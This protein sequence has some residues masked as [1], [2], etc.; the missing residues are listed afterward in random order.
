[1]VLFRG[2]IEIFLL[3]AII[4]HDI[5]PILYFSSRHPVI[6]I[7]PILGLGTVR[8]SPVAGNA[9]YRVEFYPMI[10][11]KTGLKKEQNK[12]PLANKQRKETSVRPYIQKLQKPQTISAQM[13]NHYPCESDLLCQGPLAGVSQQGAPQTPR[14]QYLSRHWSAG[15][16]PIVAKGQ[17]QTGPEAGRE[18]R[19]LPLLQQ[20][21]EEDPL[22][23]FLHAVGSYSSLSP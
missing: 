11:Q 20:H 8:A 7:E 3:P 22:D 23:R 18:G 10:L 21:G 14:Y 1:M 13:Y 4:P 12:E 17:E 15:F 6:V 9:P 19:Q 5:H 16:H 2:R